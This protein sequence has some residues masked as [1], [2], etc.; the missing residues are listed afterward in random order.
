MSAI[1]NQNRMA[2]MQNS[3]IVNYLFLN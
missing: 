3:R 1:Q 2:A